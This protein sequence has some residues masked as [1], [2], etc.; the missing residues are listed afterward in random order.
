MRAA[1][2]LKAHS[3]WAA[4]VTLGDGAGGV[5]EI[6]DRRRIELAVDGPGNQ[7]YHAAQPLAPAAARALVARGIA[8]ADRLAIQ[9]LRAA[10]KRAQDRGHVVAASA[11]LV[12]AP[13]PA[14]GV[15]EILAVHFRMH[16]AEG[17][18]FR[19][20]L[21]RA[22]KACGLRLVSI[23]EKHLA[24]HAEQALGVTSS[25]LGRQLIALGKS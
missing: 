13:M 25:A 21:V 1:F 22:T 18:L 24:K 19:D 12:G 23:P 14:W 4:L 16:K 17:V 10:M 9:E 2:G 7:P 5:L 15:D 11:V 20:A 6:I 3:G 8:A